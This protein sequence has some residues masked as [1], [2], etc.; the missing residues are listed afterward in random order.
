M[1][2]N[3]VELARLFVSNLR[4]RREERADRKDDPI[5]PYEAFKR[6]GERAASQ[7]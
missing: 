4:V 3:L 1:I 5:G 6:L 7:P 2:Q